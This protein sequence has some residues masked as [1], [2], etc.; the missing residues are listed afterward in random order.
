MMAAERRSR[1]PGEVSVSHVAAFAVV[2]LAVSGVVAAATI[3]DTVSRRRFDILRI[4]R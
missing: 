1:V 2:T 3:D 4:A